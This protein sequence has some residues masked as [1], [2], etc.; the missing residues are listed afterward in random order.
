MTSPAARP[1]STRRIFSWE[2]GDAEKCPSSVSCRLRAPPRALFLSFPN[3]LSAD[4]GPASATR[5]R[6]PH[7]RRLRGRPGAAPLDRGRRSSPLLAHPTGGRRLHHLAAHSSAC[8]LLPAPSTGAESNCPRSDR[9][10]ASRAPSRRARSRCRRHRRLRPRGRR[11]HDA[12]RTTAAA[13]LGAPEIPPL[14][15]KASNEAPPDA[16]QF[17]VGIS[18]HGVVRFCFLERSSGDP[19]LDAQA[20]QHLL[21]CRFPA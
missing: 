6:Q 12:F 11:H 1:R 2:T 17:R 4:R 3:H 9:T 19:A 7:H 21:L 20:R 16:A 15:F 5:P 10:S 13:R 14:H 8:A 18:A